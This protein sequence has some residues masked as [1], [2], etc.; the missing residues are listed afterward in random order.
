[1]DQIIATHLS[2]PLNPQSNPTKP[3]PIREKITQALDEVRTE[4]ATLNDTVATLD[5]GDEGDEIDEAVGGTNS[6]LVEQKRKEMEASKKRTEEILEKLNEYEQGKEIN[7]AQ[8]LPAFRNFVIQTSEQQKSMREQEIR[9]AEERK[10][11]MESQ[12]KRKQNLEKLLTDLNESLRVQPMNVA[13]ATTDKN[14][15]QRSDDSDDSRQITHSQSKSSKART[16]TRSSP[17]NTINSTDSSSEE[18]EQAGKRE[19]KGNYVGKEKRKHNRKTE[20]RNKKKKNARSD[21][22]EETLSLDSSESSESS[23]FSRSSADSS[24]DS[25]EEERKKRKRHQK[26]K[27]A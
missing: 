10:K 23:D 5:S 18:I 13:S 12:M 8:L 1:M 24:S 7:M 15:S 4:I 20:I 3:K 19:L 9:M 27:K 2:K 6:S 11:E 14:D 17:K 25:T 22:S 16:E 21:S 26:K